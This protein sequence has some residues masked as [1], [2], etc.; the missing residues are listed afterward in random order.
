[1]V[2][3]PVAPPPISGGTLAVSSDGTYAFAADSDR[4]ALYVIDLKTGISVTVALEAG[5][6]PG[7]VVEDAAGRVHVA[8]RGAGAVASIDPATSTVLGRTSVCP[9]PR[10]IAYMAVGDALYVACAGGELVTLPAAGGVVTRTVIVEPDLRDVVV[11]GSN[12]YLSELRTAAIL[13]LPPTDRLP[14]ASRGRSRTSSRGSP[15]E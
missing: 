15:G 14:I 10:G 5:D 9:R 2:T 13:K 6:E 3:Q 12:V 11:V 4:D 8:L 7:R 1:M